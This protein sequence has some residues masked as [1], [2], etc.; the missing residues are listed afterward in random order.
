MLSES[1]ILNRDTC[2]GVHSLIVP[3]FIKSDRSHCAGRR[4]L[5]PLTDPHSLADTQ[6]SDSSFPFTPST[7]IDSGWWMG[8]VVV[9]PQ[10]ALRGDSVMLNDDGRGG[11]SDHID[12]APTKRDIAEK[13]T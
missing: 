8:S 3:V 9:S 6:H 13:L 12:T 4:T 7:T 10:A 2:C 11:D 5:K 1:N